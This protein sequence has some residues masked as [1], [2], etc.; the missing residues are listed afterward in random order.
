MKQER[1]CRWQGL[2]A[3]ILVLCVLMVSSIGAFA[4]GPQAPRVGQPAKELS[5]EWWQWAYS[6]PPSVNPI[7]DTT[8]ED[9]VLGQRGDVW[10]LAGTSSPG[11]VVRNCSVP[12]GKVLFFPVVN[13]VIF[14]SPNACG[15]DSNSMSVEFMRD[16][17]APIVDGATDMSVTLDG[18]EVRKIHRVRSEVFEISLPK[19]NLYL[20]FNPSQTPCEGV[21]SPAVDDGY[22][23]QIKPLKPGP[24][25][26]HISGKLPALGSDVNVTYNLTVV[27]VK[28]K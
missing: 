21:Y 5:A 7:L 9:C 20:Y 12:E 22:Y 3:G 8:G 18:S 11:A 19:D 13:L 10:F 2:A 16:L 17:L 28:L 26:V 27:P 6:L 15:Q 25:T 4:E 23:A 14:D 1:K 24:H